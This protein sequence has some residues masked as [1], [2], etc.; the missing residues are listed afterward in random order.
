MNKYH[1]IP[2]RV[3]QHWQEKDGKSEEEIQEIRIAFI[4]DCLR[5]HR[6]QEEPKR[7]TKHKSKNGKVPAFGKLLELNKS[8][9]IPEIARQYGVSREA[10]YLYFRRAA[11]KPLKHSRL[12]SAIL[13]AEMNK[14][15]S[16]TEMAKTLKVA[17]LTIAR[18]LKKAGFEPVEQRG[19]LRGEAYPVEE[20]VAL[21]QKGLKTREVAAELNRTTGAILIG[22]Y[23]RDLTVK[24]IRQGA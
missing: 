4:K 6:A 14:S 22:L 17:P 11:I 2:A 16:M 9:A 1:P 3:V 20:V 23:R 19:G 8:L 12:P 21:F 13:L 10:I 18:H 24:E 15:S 5:R 7:Y